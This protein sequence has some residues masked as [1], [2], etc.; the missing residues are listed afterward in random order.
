MRRVSS[1]RDL[2]K[3]SHYAI[4]DEA[5]ID[6]VRFVGFTSESLALF[7]GCESLI[8]ADQTMEEVWVNRERLNR[9]IYHIGEAP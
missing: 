9:Y 7:V 5:S 2:V 1:D 6:L 4:E 3:N 8:R